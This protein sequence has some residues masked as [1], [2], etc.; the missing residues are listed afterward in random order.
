M[1]SF[2]DIRNGPDSQYVLGGA[3]E[4]CPVCGSDRVLQVA[5][6]D[7]YRCPDCGRC[8]SLTMRG[9]RRVDPVTC[10]GCM[11]RSA[12]FERLRNEFPSWEPPDLT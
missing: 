11:D 8:W 1:E 4:I 10:P 12:C 5:G 9:P 2:L 7:S 6:H 3:I